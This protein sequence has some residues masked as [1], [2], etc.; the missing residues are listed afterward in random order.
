MTDA[1]LSLSDE[2]VMPIKL[3]PVHDTSSHSADGVGAVVLCK[4]C[5]R[6]NRCF[7]DDER[8]GYA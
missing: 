2:W 5:G 6:R 3:C 7:P 4:S 1:V 8:R